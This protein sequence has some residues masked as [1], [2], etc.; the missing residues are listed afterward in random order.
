M[1]S[2]KTPGQDPAHL[3]LVEQHSAPIDVLQGAF[4][5]FTGSE[6]RARMSFATIAAVGTTAI[7]TFKIP[8]VTAPSLALETLQHTNNPVISGVVTGLVFGGWTLG[9]S[10]IIN[11]AGNHYPSAKDRAKV[12][13]PRTLEFL[14]E[15]LPG[16]HAETNKVDQTRTA[17]RKTGTLTHANRGV[18]VMGIGAGFYVAASQLEDKSN[19]EIQNLRRVCS[20]D[21]AIAVGS[22]SLVVSTIV[23]TLRDSHPEAAELIED[24]STNPKALLLLALALITGQGL[25]KWRKRRRTPMIAE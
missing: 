10:G 5:D 9:A 14:S 16:L 24:Q 20:M 7:N 23:D 11:A 3:N 21:A 1:S 15:S 25:N 12:R 18:A 17:R 6:R 4:N 8:L 22:V 2:P 19:E 13:Y